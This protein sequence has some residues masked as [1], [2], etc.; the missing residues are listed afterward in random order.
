[1]HCAKNTR[2]PFRSLFSRIQFKCGKIQSRK[3]SKFGHFSGSFYIGCYFGLSNLAFLNVPMTSTRAV[4]WIC[5]RRKREIAPTSL[6]PGYFSYTYG[7]CKC[8]RLFHLMY[9]YFICT[10]DETRA[11]RLF[12]LDSI[13]SDLCFIKNFNQQLAEL[14]ILL[15]SKIFYSN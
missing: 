7:V 12:N 4:S 8:F 14:I 9:V 10:F 15:C 6:L 3:N 1:M 13:N 11:A 5:C 2:V